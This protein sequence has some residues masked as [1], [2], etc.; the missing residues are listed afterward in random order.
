MKK[1]TDKNSLTN[2]CQCRRHKRCRFNSW[3]RKILWKGNGNPLQ[4]S[5]LENLHGQR[6]LAGCSPWGSR[7]GHNCTLDN[8]CSLLPGEKTLLDLEASLEFPHGGERY[9]VREILSF[10][11]PVSWPSYAF[12]Q[13]DGETGSFKARAHR[14]TRALSMSG[15]RHL[16]AQPLEGPGGRPLQGPAKGTL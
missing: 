6:S 15:H 1:K 5:C 2:S 4:Y 3:V 8:N 9:S 14:Q 13:C 7:V 12:G 10:L 16:R 11:L